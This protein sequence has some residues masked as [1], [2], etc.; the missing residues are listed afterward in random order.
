VSRYAG[1][2][3][4]QLDRLFNQGTVA[5]LTEGKLLERFVEVRDE[6]AF[7]ALVSRHGPMVLGVCRR[8]LRDENDVEDAFQ[9]TFLVLVRR[10]GAIGRGDLVS[11][12]LHG[13][14]HRVA[15]RAR[16]QAARR[17]VHEPTG[18]EL[19][20]IS[21]GPTSGEG[22]R[23]DLR[24]ILDEEL[25][26]LPASLRSPVILCY[27]EGMTHDEAAQFLG[28]PVGTVRSR[29]ARARDVL[30]RRLVRQGFMTDGS[31]L[32]A[33]LVRE[34]APLSLIDSTVQASLGFAA[35]QATAVGVVSTTAAALARGVLHAM[36]I[37][38]IKL[39][40]AAAVVGMIALGGAHTLAR[41][42]GGTGGKEPP[43]TVLP[44]KVDREDA[45]LRSVDKIDEALDDMVRRNHELQTEVRDLR[46][47]IAAL[48]SGRPE[49][50]EKGA[51][52]ASSQPDKGASRNTEIAIRALE[53][54]YDA[55]FI[56]G[57]TKSSVGRERGPRGAAADDNGTP[58]GAIDSGPLHFENG[59]YIL[60][61][62]PEGDRVAIYDKR[63]R[64]SKLLELP[65][66]KGSRHAV[67]PIWGNGILALTIR[68]PKISR[69]AV[70]TI[71]G[72]VDPTLEGW[73]P[74]ELREPVDQ[75]S[76][77]CKSMSAAYVL[78]RYVYAFS[79]N[80]KRWDVLELPVGSHPQLSGSG[81][82]FIVEHGSHLHRFNEFGKWDDIDFNGILSTTMPPENVR[83]PGTQ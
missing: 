22:S 73:Y 7:A 78:G 55:P 49:I 60:V 31:A 38:K 37:S 16:A 66:P 75:V 62:S 43:Q 50:I 24:M 83:K 6:A 8:I 34:P 36:M 51:S 80:A 39:F 68:G 13:V 65:V 52:S 47:Q 53:Q 4:K 48:R 82:E 57:N 10:A 77:I 30:R 23:H 46:K 61:T 18:L 41:Q 5:G 74:Q 72:R 33:V 71:Y 70:Y 76:V 3:L 27:L 67:T 29:L 81:N 11:H 40:G 25:E 35:K 56:L 28:C 9:A 2:V 44:P 14:A 64:G 15:V 69:I 79:A 59:P 12:W 54:A 1:A 32:T 20:E 63:T 26:R 21:A 42:H 17:H 45:L 58:A 19:D